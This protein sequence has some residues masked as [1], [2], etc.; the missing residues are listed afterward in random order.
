M[1][2]VSTTE[3]IHLHNVCSVE[4]AEGEQFRQRCSA[5]AHQ[6]IGVQQIGDGLVVDLQ[7]GDAH[8]K[9]LPRMGRV[10]DEAEDVL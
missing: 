9:F 3:Y 8:E 10:L 6:A 7:E 1:Q 4:Q 5:R 2:A